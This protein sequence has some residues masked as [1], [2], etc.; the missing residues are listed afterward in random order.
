[1]ALEQITFNIGA[2][3]DS[4]AGGN[5][6][7][8]DTVFEVK[9]QSDNTFATIYADSSGTTQ[10]P[11]NGIDNVSNSRGECNF[12]IDDGDFYLE[13]NSQQKNFNTGNF[14]AGFANI[15]EVKAY[16]KLSKLIGQRVTIGEYHAGT[17]YGGASYNVVSSA[18]VTPN[19]IDVIQGVADS[20][21]AISL[22]NIS[23]PVPSQFGCRIGSFNNS[24][25]L[26]RYAEYC[27]EN[28]TKFIFDKPYE[29][30]DSVFI[31]SGVVVDMIE[32]LDAAKAT[33]LSLGAALVIGSDSMDKLAATL[34]SD[35][36]KQ[37]LII[38]VT[39]SGE[40]SAGDVISIYNPTDFSYHPARDYYRDGELVQ[41]QSIDG[42]Q[43]TL[44]KP[45]RS[46]Y[47]ASSM[48]L[49]KLRE[50]NNAELKINVNC[51]NI[52]A[53]AFQIN[54]SVNMRGYISGSGGN[55]GVLDRSMCFDCDWD[56]G[57]IMQTDSSTT[58]AYGIANRNSSY[59]RDHGGSVEA[60]RHAVTNTGRGGEAR[61]PCRG[62]R[63]LNQ[64]ISN[65]A[66]VTNTSAWDCHAVA[67]DCFAINCDIYGGVVSGG[68]N[69]GTPNCRIYQLGTRAL[70]KEGNL[71]NTNQNYSGCEMHLTNIVTANAALASFGSIP[72][73]MEVDITSGGTIDFS[74]SKVYMG[75][76]DNATPKA[77]ISI[78]VRSY[79]GGDVDVDFSG[80]NVTCPES[81][82]NTNIIQID[83]NSTNRVRKVVINNSYSEGISWL[84]DVCE[85]KVDGL[86]VKSGDR[87][88]GS[89]QGFSAEVDGSA[90]I[91]NYYL[92]GSK[93]QGLALSS[94]N[95]AK[96]TLSNINVSR[97]NIL[98]STNSRV[99]SGVSVEGCGNVFANGINA[100]IDSSLANSYPINFRDNGDVV[101]GI[102]SYSG[103][104][105]PIQQSGN[106]SFNTANLGIPAI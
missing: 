49:W 97:C 32:P 69:N 90:D 28:N 2:F 78:T 87:T 48:E 3:N 27:K 68:A 58:L 16:P 96:V 105:D 51:S 79:N 62:N 61:P 72:G 59:Q 37:G 41:I 101:L 82:S 77:L 33:S 74:N 21:A 44:T 14:K 93:Y 13:V 80:V 4:D 42:N 23:S 35:P 60:M 8:T 94:S 17:G 91:S 106:L 43:I 22:V 92:D 45:L 11:Q 104:T 100:S 66:E 70:I 84:L 53:F 6:Y 7:F 38:S 85:L 55:W 57:S 54:G 63:S 19:D 46:G 71:V 75:G 83:R 103:F 99:R 36:V 29:S 10:I 88:I 40:M 15:D 81:I 64:T 98:T 65:H 52:N 5:N 89:V 73:E 39:S 102:N 47:L 86:E 1:M 95:S 31:P 30:Y 67:E 25:Q 34:S 18:S 20:G 9:N 50:P 56:V 26:N 12:Y 24:T 76:S